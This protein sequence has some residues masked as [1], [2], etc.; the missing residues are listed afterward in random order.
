MEKS[1]IKQW[2]LLSKLL[3]NIV[4]QAAVS[5]LKQEKETTAIRIGEEEV[6]PYAEM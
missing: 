1:Q 5:A 3:F 6:K 4:L 2:C